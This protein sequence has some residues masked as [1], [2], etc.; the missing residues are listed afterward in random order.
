MK[1]KL[2]EMIVMGI[3]ILYTLP[4]VGAEQTTEQEA[5]RPRWRPPQVQVDPAAQARVQQLGGV[6]IGVHDPSTIVKC[7]DEYWIFYTGGGCPSYHSKDLITWERGP[8]AI[9]TAPEWL[10][11]V[12]PP[13]GGRG[14]AAGNR[15][16]RV[17]GFWAP[18]IIHLK[19]KYLLYFSYSAF[20]VNTSGIALATNPTL[21]P[22]DPEYNWTEQGLVVTSDRSK[23][24]NAIDPA[25]ILDEGGRL[26]M[27]FGSFWS[28]IQ[29]IELDPETGKRI[30]SD[31]PMYTLATYDSIEAPFI[32]FHD[33]YYYLFVDWGMCCRGANSTYNMRVGRSKAVT[34]PYLDKDGVDMRERGGTLLLETDGP[35][36]GPGHPG[37]IKVDD[38]YWLGMHFYNG[39]QGGRSQYALRPLEWED[40]GWPVVITPPQESA[41]SVQKDVDS[42]PNEITITRDISYREGNSNAWKLD[43]VMPADSGDQLRP[44]LVIVHGGGWGAGS[45]SVDV[46][47]K[48]MTDYARKGY[49]TINVEY[50][51][52]GEAPFPACIE[53]VKCAVRWLRAH[54]DEYRVDPDRI[55]AYGHSAGAHLALMLAMVPKAAGLEGDGGWEEYS[56]RVNVAV[57]GSPPTE[58]GRDTPMSKTEWWPIGYISGDQPPLFLIQGSED[59][60][61][62]PELT[63]DFVEK[64]KAAGASIEYLEI[65]GVGHDVA[66]SAKLEITD[67]AI[68]K[69]F[70][71]HLKVKAD[72]SSRAE[73][74]SR[75]T[76]SR[77]VEDGG[78]GPYP[79]VMVTDGT[80]STHTIFRPKDLSIFSQ[81]HPL[82]IIAWGNGACAN[83]PWEHVNFLSEV[84]SHGFMVIAIGVMPQEGRRDYGKSTASQL[85]DAI[86]W[87]IA[88]NDNKA[89]QYY[90]KI[91]ITKISVS[92]MSCGGL[93]T[94]EVAPDPRITTA[95]IC[96]S[97]ILS[98]PGSGMPGMPGL[99]KDQLEKLHSPTLYI[100]GGESDIAYNN[101]MD[102]FQ[103]IDHVP[104]F[105]A[106]LNVGHGGTYAR[107]HGGDFAK[108]AT[109]WFK[110][111]LKDDNEAGNMFMGQ[112]CGVEQMA[113]W[114][115]KKKN[116]L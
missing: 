13:R 79:A 20:G 53:D 96:N 26:W 17:P 16:Q 8:Q 76:A 40:D 107:P 11:E 15:P 38:V 116:I 57:A 41:S 6:D 93:Q 12:V 37:I 9:T 36:I 32:Y 84:A 59:R 65:D 28:G 4:A 2:C 45:K 74:K 64:M 58:L 110:W 18:D 83:S 85:I 77:T 89:S 42:K 27:S 99:I 106:N 91:D 111:H 62:R 22:D 43:M 115:A 56:S 73:I 10:S 108:V 61:V 54:A 7:K 87:A 55:G 69:F 63:E 66:Y 82:P 88:Q 1:K 102:D 47:Q 46:Y 44:A 21:D 78:T 51:L 80:L 94:L 97:G 72:E 67:P 90:N 105:A 52:T 24:Y 81:Q 75:E 112:P 92:G 29:L 68:E 33:G 3:I 109:A 100:L 104:V 98:N 95:V 5:P 60:I 39:A 14:D 30:A 48:M 25:L 114:K 50:R 23:D 49:V 19:D 103:R 86:D 101:G 70:A 71:K 35:F 31:S 34:G 113:G